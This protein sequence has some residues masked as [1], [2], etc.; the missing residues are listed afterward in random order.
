MALNLGLVGCGDIAGFIGLLAGLTPQARLSACCDIDDNRA[1]RFAR[2]HRIPQ[3][4]NDYKE[5]L[6]N[7]GIEAVYLAAPHHLH[8][9]MILA[10]VRAGLPVLVEKP[11]TRTLAEGQ[12]LVQAAAGHKIG[13]NYQYRYD[14]GC[15]ALAR[16]VQAGALGAV[17]SVRINVPWRRTATYFEGAAWHKTIAQAG[18]GA[19]I[20]QGSHFLD[21][22]LWALDEKPLTAMGYTTRPGFA[23]EVETL[24]HGMVQTE[25]GALIHI[26]SSMVAARESAVTIEV[27]GQRGTARYSNRPWPAVR[28]EGVQVRRQRP[29]VWGVHALHRSLA[30]FAAWVTREQP[31]LTPASQALPVL[32]AVDGIYRSAQSGRRVE[33]Q[34]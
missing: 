23:V 13:V 5:M 19:L 6:A 30:G 33:V 32:A 18:G 28:F 9:E 12:A 26:C 29:P 3:V 8:Y 25:S 4:Y 1:Q 10:A 11:L 34:C 15:Y 27:Y 2:R 14:R 20:T 17:H 21:V 22:A 7:G 16:A 24:A 31:Y